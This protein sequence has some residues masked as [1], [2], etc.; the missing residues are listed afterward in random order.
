MAG[1]NSNEVYLLGPDQSTTTGAVLKAA[2]GATAPT[3]AR[4][5]LG[6]GWNSA[7]G[8]LSEAGI[9]L[10]INRSTTSIKDWGLNS[11]RTAT[12]DFTTNIT[13]EFLQMDADTAKTLFGEANVTVTAATT[14]TPAT[15]KISIGPD[16][17]NPA[18][19]AL[20]MKDGNRRGRIYVPNGQITVVGS[21]TFVPGAGNVW[22]FTLE[23]YDDGTGHCV[24][25]FL[26]DGTV[27]SA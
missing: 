3:D 13:G 20:N 16:M 8:Y 17:P 26:D 12:T 10:N 18:A 4:T 24:Y 19:F 27:Q 7:A 23:C 11:V 1:V 22:P 25:L 6:T 9:T 21:P 2:I 15:L 5:A 14:T